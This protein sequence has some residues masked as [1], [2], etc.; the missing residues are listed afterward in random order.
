MKYFRILTILL[1]LFIC[2]NLNAQTPLPSGSSYDLG[3]SPG[4][5]SLEVVLKAIN[6]SKT[7]LLIAC[8]E[9]TDRDIAEAIESAAHRGVNIRVVAE[10]KDAQEK[11]SMRGE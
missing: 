8:Y 7:S 10:I 6:A 11:Y 5:T 3:F 1:V 2:L 4:G 9:F